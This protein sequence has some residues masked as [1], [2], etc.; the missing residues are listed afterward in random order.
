MPSEDDKL[1]KHNHGEKSIKAP[2]IIY[3][4]LECFLKKIN[5]YYSNSKSHQQPK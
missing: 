5:T 3:D 1:L 2:F 4:N